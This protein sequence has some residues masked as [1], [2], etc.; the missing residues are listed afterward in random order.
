MKASRMLGVA[1]ATLIAASVGADP[2]AAQT[3][4]L[5]YLSWGNAHFEQM[6]KDRFAAFEELHPDVEMEWIDQKGP[7]WPGYFQTQVMAGS[8][9]DILQ[10]QGSL[11]VQYAAQGG[12]VDLTPYL[13]RDGLLDRYEP[14]V[15]ETYKYQGRYYLAPYG[16][17]KTMLFYNKPMLAEA[18]IDSPPETFE[19]LIADAQTLTKDGK[20]GFISLNFDWMYW[21]LFAANGVELLNEDGTEAAFNTPAAV[22]ALQTLAEATASGAIDKTTWSGRWFEIIDPFVEG[23]V[24]M[25]HA[26]APAFLWL[27]GRGQEWVDNDTLGM[28][29][30]PGHIATPDNHGFAISASSEHPDLAWEFI[31]LTTNDEFAEQYVREGRMLSGNVEVNRRMMEELKAE[32]PMLH[33]MLQIQSEN[34]DKLVGVWPNPKDGE[35]KEAVYAEVQNAVLGRK[36]AADA[37]A[38]AERKVNRLLSR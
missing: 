29:D 10:I 6:I 5:T 35:V 24:A 15:M 2:A 17:Y 7:D 26:H 4:K 11:W 8:A 38:D 34:W 18:G 20:T 22:E 14:G 28:A 23:Q 1:L 33:R 31:K 37:L 21:P 16:M 19:E 25:L 30:F 3:K 32:A 13:E 36:S 12:L 27:E 9:P